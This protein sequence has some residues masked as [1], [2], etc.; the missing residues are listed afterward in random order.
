[1]D[2]NS[3]IPWI[4]N[5][6]VDV[7]FRTPSSP[8][9]LLPQ[10]EKDS[11][12]RQRPVGMPISGTLAKEPLIYM[13][14]VGNKMGGSVFIREYDKEIYPSISYISLN[15]SCMTPPKKASWVDFMLDGNWNYGEHDAEDI[16]HRIEIPGPFMARLYE[17]WFERSR[18]PA[19]ENWRKVIQ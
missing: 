19:V 5:Q 9:Y 10:T 16:A 15:R 12:W 1:M 11:E 17:L 7:R 2:Q 3:S 13:G 8:T 6:T 18:K 14:V 4:N